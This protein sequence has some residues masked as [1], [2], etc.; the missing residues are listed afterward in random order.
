MMTIVD[1]ICSRY[2]PFHPILWYVIL[3]ENGHYFFN[4]IETT[5]Y[6]PVH[7]FNLENGD[8]TPITINDIDE[9]FEIYEREQ[10][11]MEIRT[12]NKIMSIKHYIRDKK[13][14][15][16]LNDGGN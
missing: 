16:I 9:Y 6:E 10:G 14:D 12:Y 5:E 1:H 15:S 4:I 8:P 13:I 7:S 11:K 3:E 2:S